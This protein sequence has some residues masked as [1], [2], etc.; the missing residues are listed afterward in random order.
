MSKTRPRAK[1]DL[2]PRKL[3]LIKGGLWGTN[4]KVS[5]EDTMAKSVTKKVRSEKR[6]VRDLAVKQTAG[7][8]IQGGKGASPLLTKACATGKH[9]PTVVI[10][11]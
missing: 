2:E 8:N 5:E 9:Y 4:P 11:T 1:K 10:T 3:R 7:A 6:R